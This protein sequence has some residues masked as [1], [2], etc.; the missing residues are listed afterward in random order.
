MLRMTM[1]NLGATW[2]PNHHHHLSYVC[3]CVCTR[4]ARD[5]QPLCPLLFFW[6][7]LLTSGRLG[8]EMIVNLNLHFALI[9]SLA[10]AFSFA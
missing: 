10:L 5:I 3:V 6:L 4:N 7:T 8:I 1:E 2:Q 9:N